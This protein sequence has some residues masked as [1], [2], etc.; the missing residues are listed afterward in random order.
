MCRDHWSDSRARIWSF[1]LKG[2]RGMSTYIRTH[3]VAHLRVPRLLN[4]SSMF[5]SKREGDSENGSGKS[6]NDSTTSQMVPQGSETL[7][8]IYRRCRKEIRSNQ[9]IYGRSGIFWKVKPQRWTTMG[10]RPHGAH[11]W[12]AAPLAG[13]VIVQESTPS[14]VW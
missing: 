1:P 13:G 8:L 7:P 11:P 10:P 6:R 3:W 4:M 12:P 14:A 9:N 5:W 2:V